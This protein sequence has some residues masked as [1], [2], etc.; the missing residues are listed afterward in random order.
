MIN[1]IP[2]IIIIV[3]IIAAIII[4]PIA[5]ISNVSG[6]PL[7]SR[8]AFWE[9]ASF[10]GAV[11]V[12]VG[13]V[14]EVFEITE[15]AFIKYP[16]LESKF[17]SVRLKSAKEFFLKWEFVIEAVGFIVVIAGLVVELGGSFMAFRLSN[18]RDKQSQLEIEE[19]KNE[20]IERQRDIVLAGHGRWAAIHPETISKE[21]DGKPKMPVVLLYLKDD[22]EAWMAAAYIG[23]GLEKAGWK[24]E[25]RELAESD[26]PYQG[27]IFGQTNAP[28]SVR[29]STGPTGAGFIIK[30]RPADSGFLIKTDNPMGALNWAL[31][32]GGFW[33]GGGTYDQTMPE[34]VIK[35]ILVQKM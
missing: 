6:R 32:K 13:I 33:L 4:I 21:L 23:I 12:I 2:I 20:N 27:T 5:M 26:V 17:N 24:F 3:E 14:I 28:L 18:E 9:Y 10:F 31:N 22:G 16:S 29:A 19:L 15:K 34:N 7:D 1:A 35:I 11:T 8:I 25:I 30:S